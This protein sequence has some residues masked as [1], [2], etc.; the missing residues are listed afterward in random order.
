[1]TCNVRN[2]LPLI[3]ACALTLEAGTAAVSADTHDE[4]HE[5]FRIAEGTPVVVKNTNGDIHVSTWDNDYAEVHADLSSRYGQE[6]ID[7]VAIEVSV[8]GAMTI[9]SVLSRREGSSLLDHLFGSV[10]R[11]PRVDVNYTIRLPRTAQLEE[12]ATVNGSIEFEQTRGNALARTTN[13]KVQV[14]GHRGGLEARSTNGDIIIRGEVELRRASTT[15]GSIEAAVA[16][17][18]EGTVEIETVNGPVD[19]TLAEGMNVEIEVKTVNGG[20]NANGITMKLG[21][22]SKNHLTGT[23][24]SGGPRLS[25]RTVNGSVDLMVRRPA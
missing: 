3:L 5:T 9:E 18:L 19:V 1:M 13:G 24:G 11:W 22:V 2:I 8:D 16:G 17:T 4:Y 6:E 14:N 7:L 23:I 15:N 25:I 10:G 12:V 20:I 21:S